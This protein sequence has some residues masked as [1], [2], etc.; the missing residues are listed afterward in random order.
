VYL[1]D[2][3]SRNGAIF[4][5]TAHNTVLLPFLE[6][7]SEEDQRGKFAWA[8]FPGVYQVPRGERGPV[9]RDCAQLIALSTITTP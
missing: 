5:P 2:R 8:A 7:M 9:R 1:G 3:T 6:E 4:Q